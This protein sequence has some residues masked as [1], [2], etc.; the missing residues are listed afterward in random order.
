MSSG[1]PRKG[2]SQ[3][4]DRRRG[5]YGRARKLELHADTLAAVPAPSIS[6]VVVAYDM[7]RELPRTLR[8]L[9]SQQ[10]ID[11]SDVLVPLV[12]TAAQAGV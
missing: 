6:V 4:S 2:Q 7:A 5:R 8:T 10:G 11:P 1:C 12:V 3:G 9:R